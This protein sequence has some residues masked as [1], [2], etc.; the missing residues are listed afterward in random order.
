MEEAS[1]ERRRIVLGKQKGNALVEIFL[2]E[3]EGWHGGI[4]AIA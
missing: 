3:I 1:E 4:R 2:A